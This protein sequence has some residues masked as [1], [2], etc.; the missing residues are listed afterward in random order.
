[1]HNGTHED[2]VCQDVAG[3]RPTIQY[4]PDCSGQGG[5]CPDVIQIESTAEH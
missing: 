1:M 5:V 4:Y 2:F 3:L